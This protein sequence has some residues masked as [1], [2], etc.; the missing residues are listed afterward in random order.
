MTATSRPPRRS[1]SSRPVRGSTAR[2]Y[3]D[4]YRTAI[5]STPDGS[6]ISYAQ[7][8]MRIYLGADYALTQ[9]GA[10]QAITESIIAGS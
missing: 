5:S 7:G 4:W 1:H 9:Q 6:H 10:G 8:T 2:A 3:G